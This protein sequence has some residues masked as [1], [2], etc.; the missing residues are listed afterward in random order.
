M[1]DIS[2]SASQFGD[3]IRWLMSILTKFVQGIGI[4]EIIFIFVILGLFVLWINQEKIDPVKV[5]RRF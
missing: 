4:T 2:N 5:N 1:V 3:L